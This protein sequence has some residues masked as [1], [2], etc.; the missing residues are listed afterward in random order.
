MV[1]KGGFSG[2]CSRNVLLHSQ[3]GH[4][5]LNGMGLGSFVLLC[6]DLRRWA[7]FSHAWSQDGH[8]L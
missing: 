3:I 4:N 5:A 8:N 1:P 7:S 6:L 2:G